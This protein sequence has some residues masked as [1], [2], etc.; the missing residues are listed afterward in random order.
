MGRYLRDAAL[1]YAEQWALKRNPM[2]VN[3][4][5]LGGDCTNFVSQCLYSGCGE[6]NYTPDTGWFYTNGYK[7]T[8]SWTGVEFLYQFLVTNT[9]EG[10]R[11]RVADWGDLKPGDLSQIGRGESGF[12]HTQIIIAIEGPEIY[13]AAHS[14]DEWM[15]PLSD[16]DYQRV[17]FLRVLDY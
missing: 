14:R 2:Y 13:I 16:Y 9:K 12:H 8:P 10:P 17:R 4:D 15:R 3:F 7:R 1:A 5:Q 11:A 6:M